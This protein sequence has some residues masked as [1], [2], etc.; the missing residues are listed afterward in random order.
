ML[1]TLVKLNSTAATAAKTASVEASG[2]SAAETRAEHKAGLSAET[3]EMI[4]REIY[5]L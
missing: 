2:S 1:D 3:I 4:K 5:G